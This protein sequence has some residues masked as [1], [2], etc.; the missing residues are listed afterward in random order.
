[1]YD[2]LESQGVADQRGCYGASGGKVIDLYEEQRGRGTRRSRG[3]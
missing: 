3:W 2:N 1:M